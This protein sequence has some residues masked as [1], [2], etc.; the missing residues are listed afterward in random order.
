MSGGAHHRRSRPH[1]WSGLRSAKNKECLTVLNFIG[2]ANSK[3]NFEDYLYFLQQCVN[4]KR[5]VSR[6]AHKL[7]P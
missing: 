2:Q 5:L 7:I 1:S 6:A 4:L 3:Y